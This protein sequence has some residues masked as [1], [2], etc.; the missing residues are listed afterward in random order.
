M[1]SKT[2]SATLLICG[3]FAIFGLFFIIPTIGAITP[4]GMRL[5]GLFLAF[6]YGMTVTTDPW[7]ALFTVV[8]FPATGLVDMGNVLSVGFGNDT[9]IFVLFSLVL[10]RYM[11]TSGAANF[12][13]TW[14]LKR[15]ILIGHPWRLIFMLLFVC[16]LISSFVNAVAGLMITWTFIYQIFDYF[17]YKPYEKTSTVIMFGTCVV[18]GLGLASLPWSNNSLVILNAFTNVTGIEVDYF[19]YMGY[20]IPFA[21]MAIFLYV[22]LCK[23]VFHADVSA[24]KQYDPSIF[25]DN[26]LVLTKEKRAA[27][28]SVVALV[29]I[30]LLPTC[31]PA[32]SLIAVVSKKMALSGKLLLIFA[33]LEVICWQGKKVFD[34]TKLSREGMNWKLMLL[35]ADILVFSSLIGSEDAGIS[36]FL[37]HILS[38]IFVGRPALFLIILATIAT[39]ICTNFMVNKIVA[40]L[41]ISITMPIATQLNINLVQLVTLYTVSCTIAFM[42]PSASQS[43]TVFFANSEWARPKDIF[44]YGFVVLILLTALSIVWNIIYFR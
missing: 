26:A 38:P 8:L 27:L 10:V 1:E 30:I 42:L 20:S 33:I 14:L 32:D 12:V 7:P 18:G 3:Y 24:M 5:V 29:L 19:L 25:D 6:V 23:Y 2:N 40:V 41:M 4:A 11:E 28:L 37:S 9:F 31:F 39:V 35:V 21:I 22:A 13:T 43:S 15:K 34:F 36:S 17:G 16:W 44:R